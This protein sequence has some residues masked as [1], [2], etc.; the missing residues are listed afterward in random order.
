M[1]RVNSSDYIKATK[2]NAIY[3]ELKLNSK[4]TLPHT[5]NP[6]KLNGHTYNN[7]FN[8]LLS[9]NCSPTD[10]S[11]GCIQ[12][13][14]SYDLLLD[15][16][17][18]KYYNYIRC[19]NRQPYILHTHKIHA[20]K[21]FRI[22]NSMFAI[23]K[24]ER[25]KKSI[26][27]YR[28]ISGGT[29]VVSSADNTVNGVRLNGNN[30]EKNELLKLT[31]EGGGN[32]DILD[33][34]S[35]LTVKEYVNAEYDVNY[36]NKMDEYCKL[37]DKTQDY[38]LS[39]PKEEYRYF[40]FRYLDYI[41]YLDLPVIK[42]DSY[43]E[44]V[45]IEYRCLPQ[46]E[47]LIRNC[48]HKLRA[49]WSQTIVCGNL[50]YEYMLNIVKK[51][52]RDI[53]VIKTDYDNLMPSDYSLF[54]SSEKFWNLLIG[55]KILIYQDD[56]CI[57]KKNIMDFI[58][59]DYIGAPWNKNQN[60][61][62]NCVGNGGLSLR[63]KSI[64]LKVISKI[65]LMETEYN[66]ST[67]TY[68]KN[69][70]SIVPP[71][72]V[73]FSINMQ[74]FN[75]GKVADWNS[76][77]KF[78]S[79]SY[80]N[81]NSF[82]G[83]T[84]WISNPEWKKMLYNNNVCNFNVFKSFDTKTD[85]R[86]GWNIVKNSLKQFVNPNSDILFLDVADGHFLWEEKHKITKK[87]FGFIHL[88]PITPDYLYNILNLNYLFENKHF[89]DSLSNCLFLL[90]LSN[91]ITDFIKHKLNELGIKIEVFTIFHPTDT[92]CLKFKL[93]NYRENKNKNIIQVGQQLRKLSSI[94]CLNTQF[95]KI[96]LTGFKDQR[97]CYDML[98][99]EVEYFGY[100]NLNYESVD[101]KFVDSF[102]QYDKLFTENI[103]FID[104]FDA[105]ANNVVIECL[106]RNTP[107]LVNKISGITDYLGENYPLYFTN[108]DD[109]NNLLLD[110]NIEKAH[111]YLKTLNKE[112]LN[113]EFFTKKFVNILH[114]N[115]IKFRQMNY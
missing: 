24:M 16:N 20:Q 25:D 58:D 74:N 100:K 48:I 57:F 66:S 10:C 77:F 102:D 7:N 67:L 80:F 86:G 72:D 22:N 49:D 69:V 42:Q 64:M 63:S 1:N 65:G 47:F 23:H 108:F 40:C 38:I 103:I 3:T 4:I 110:E 78:S 51:I 2:Q 94:Y 34:K 52:D 68:M 56:T 39:N 43:Y 70:N 73:Y 60:D 83:H 90:T 15:Y 95:E 37:M 109:I 114:N 75:I 5:V 14:K 11:G 45:L 97:R 89:T 21:P 91:Y 59:W 30:I 55:E 8:I 107:L 93:E 84:F 99:R 19:I 111:N 106:A 71:E 9:K 113:I 6:V 76:A 105:A 92:Q 41:R 81:E 88:T 35:Q 32:M 50:N 27:T 29:C 87:W 98:F 12:R 33:D 96:W 28:T 62:P 112:Y 31:V 61:T 85:H 18:G 36:L 101:M 17:Q 104:L 46:L 26:Q 115:V 53:K 54:L 44:A 13:A 79:E 82:G